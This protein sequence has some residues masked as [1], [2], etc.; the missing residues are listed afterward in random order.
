MIP[1]KVFISIA[2]YREYDLEKTIKNAIDN[3]S[4]PDELRFVVCWQHADDE[5]LDLFINDDRVEVIDINYRE[6]KGVC[7]ARNL[8]QSRYDNE[9]YFLQIDGHHRFARD[10]DLR[11]IN[12]LE[13]LKADGIEKPILTTYLPSYD[14]YNDPEGRNNNVW[15]LGLDRFEPSGVVFMK[16]FLLMTTEERPIP[17]RFWSAHFSFSDG[18][19]NKE[20]VI[21]PNGYFHAEEIST[22]VRAWTHGYDFFSPNETLLWHEYS[23]KG[24]VCHWDDH[25]NWTHLHA[26]AIARYRSQFGLDGV[27]QV[28]LSPYGFGNKRSFREYERYAG[29]CFSNRG[30]EQ[31][32]I[33]N[34]VAVNTSDQRNYDEWRNSLTKS[35]DID[36][37]F[38]RDIVNES[39]STLYL[40]IFAHDSCG[41]EIFR[42]DLSRLEIDNLLQFQTDDSIGYHISFFSID[43]PIS[44]TL[45]AG[46]E[47]KGWMTR[48]D[49]VWPSPSGPSIT[50]Y[51]LK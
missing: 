11:L 5:K 12:M 24:R 26:S 29:I 20:V 48:V 13:G 37:R 36:I 28:D 9:S 8:I 2:A 47:S 38:S 39:D 23:R 35:H 32:T 19:F 1:R 30:V 51:P 25:Q 7:W 17:G 4:N 34:K 22:C 14:P 43:V 27:K 10:W 41:V 45:W 44:W 40:A 6:S 50:D 18:I 31:D 33:I 16:P 21:D 3:A 42:K 15:L 49:G 46:C